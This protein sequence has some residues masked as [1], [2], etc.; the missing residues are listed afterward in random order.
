[1]LSIEEAKKIIEKKEGKPFKLQQKFIE[2]KKARVV[3]QGGSG[4]SKKSPEDHPS[5]EKKALGKT[6]KFFRMS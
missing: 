2:A 1:M 5:I 4:C 3:V 6:L